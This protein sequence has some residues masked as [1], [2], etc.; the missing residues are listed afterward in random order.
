MARFDPTKAATL[1]LSTSTTTLEAAQRLKEE[2]EKRLARAQK[3][4][5]NTQE[6]LE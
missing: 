1:G 6:V 3:F 4:G 2:E 5:L